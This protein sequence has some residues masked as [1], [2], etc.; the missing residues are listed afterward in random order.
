MPNRERL[1]AHK[2][3]PVVYR[4]LTAPSTSVLRGIASAISLP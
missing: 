2:L 4:G 1:D 3:A